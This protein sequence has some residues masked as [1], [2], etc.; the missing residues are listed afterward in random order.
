MSDESNESTSRIVVGPHDAVPAILSRLRSGRSASATIT[1]PASSSLFLT[2]SE[3]RALKATAE[4]ARRILTIETDDGLRKQLAEMF[5]LPVVDLTSEPP[6]IPDKTSVVNLET[7]RG[8]LES[9]GG[10]AID[11]SAP[12]RVKRKRPSRP[13]GSFGRGK[14]AAIAGGALALL[15]VAGLIAAYLL[16][17]ATVEITAKR[18]PISTNVA[19][20][21][22]QGASPPAG[23]AFAIQGTKTSF[24]VPFTAQI[25]T[26]GRARTPGATAAGKVELRNTSANDIAI[27]AGTTF[28][29]FDGVQYFFPKA[30]TI[31]ASDKKT[32]TPGQATADISAS[33]GGASGNKDVGLLT[34]K[35][36]SGIYYSNRDNPIEGG[37]DQAAQGVAQADIDGLVAQANQ[38]IPQLA[39]STKVGNGLAVLPGS[40]KTGALT[41]TVD[42]KVGDQAKEL[43]INAT[44]NVT[45]TAYSPSGLQAEASKAAQS[46]LTAQVPSGYQLVADS[47]TYADPVQVS[48]P[49][50]P[51]QFKVTVNAQARAVIGDARAREIAKAVAGKSVS[52]AMAYLGTLPEAQS[53]KISSSPRFLPKRIPGNASRIT[54]KSQ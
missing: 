16:Q 3:F 1:I 35:L 31:P 9:T 53:A 45:A 22:Q 7:G 33:A 13:A 54:V 37:S 21:I 18:A 25:A 28:K 8:V 41:Y 36:D 29:S 20:V 23:A 52:D 30:V 49:D 26:T 11:A 5:G 47:L 6:P 27:A 34:G 32:K 38:Q 12:A 15:V 17:T 46:G 14:I 39:K 43:T 51:A 40:I 4:Q 19:F 50:V 2:A 42:H 24:D 44:M 48:M 10:E